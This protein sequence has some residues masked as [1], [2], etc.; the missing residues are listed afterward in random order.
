M[1]RIPLPTW[2]SLISVCEGYAYGPEGSDTALLFWGRVKGCSLHCGSRGSLQWA[3]SMACHWRERVLPKMPGS[4]NSTH[5]L[6]SC[7]GLP[8]R[9]TLPP[10]GAAE[11]EQSSNVLW[12]PA[13]L[14]SD[15]RHVHALLIQ[16]GPAGII[17]LFLWSNYLQL[18]MHRPRDPEPRWHSSSKGRTKDDRARQ[19]RPCPSSQPGTGSS[20]P[21]SPL[22]G[23][24]RP[25]H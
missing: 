6:P 10:A 22:P 3:V 18:L 25:L 13:C 1:L 17:H 12:A 15:K 24:E 8:G 5:A 11:W 4:P 20:Y 23:W 14:D 16:A 2:F 7:V 9:H 21:A 19:T